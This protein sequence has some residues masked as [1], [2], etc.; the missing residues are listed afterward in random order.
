MHS[1]CWLL[2]ETIDNYGSRV[3]RGGAN[4]NARVVGTGV[5]PV[6]TV[7]AKDGT[8]TLS[9]SAAVAGECKTVVRLDNSEMAELKVSF[10]KPTG[11]EPAGTGSGGGAQPQAAAPAAEKAAAPAEEPVDAT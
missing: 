3:D 4:I 9:F 2:H 8:Y 1:Q 6:Q 11:D 5:S 7:D 10:V